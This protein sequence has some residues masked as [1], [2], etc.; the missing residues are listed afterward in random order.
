[1]TVTIEIL[2][3]S[4]LDLLRKLESDHKIRMQPASASLDIALPKRKF[5]A[6]TIDTRGYSFNRQLANER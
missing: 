6:I 4:A 3:Q 1:M 2:H 5:E